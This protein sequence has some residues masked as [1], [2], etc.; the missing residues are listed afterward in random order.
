LGEK[1]TEP[2]GIKGKHWIIPGILNNI[3]RG[4]VSFFDISDDPRRVIGEDDCRF[5][6]SKAMLI[7]KV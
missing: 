6:V 4:L 3:K 5:V 1:P 7:S 2:N